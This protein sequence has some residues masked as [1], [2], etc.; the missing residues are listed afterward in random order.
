MNK[1]SF[2]KPFISGDELK[3]IREVLNSNKI[4]G[5]GTFTKKCQ[6]F[7]KTNINLENVF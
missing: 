2:N 7:L 5:N 1:I 6:N 3:N 4:S